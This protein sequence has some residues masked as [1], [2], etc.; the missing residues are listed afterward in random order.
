[1]SRNYGFT[2]ESNLAPPLQNYV[3]I[4]RRAIILDPNGMQ[5]GSNAYSKGPAYPHGDQ[6]NLVGIENL[7]STAPL[8]LVIQVKCEMG[9]WHNEKTYN[10]EPFAGKKKKEVK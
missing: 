7:S 5:I 10:L 1:M 9:C 3:D 4:Q 8:Q 2:P 6:I